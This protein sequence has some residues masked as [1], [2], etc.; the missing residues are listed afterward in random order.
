VKTCVISQKCLFWDKSSSL[1]NLWISFLIGEVVSPP[2]PTSGYLSQDSHDEIY[3]IYDKHM[4]LQP[5]F[6]SFYEHLIKFM[7]T[8]EI[9][10]INWSFYYHTRD[11]QPLK[12]PIHKDFERVVVDAYVYHKYCKSRCHESWDKYTKIG[13]GGETTS[14]IRSA[15]RRFPK[16]K[17]LS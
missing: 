10:W 9:S 11:L 13:V 15:I 1:G 12:L 16:D 6:Q 4:Q 14:P 3:N 17:L 8:W 7:L 2:T 5:P